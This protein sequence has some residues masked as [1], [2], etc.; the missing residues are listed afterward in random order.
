MDITEGRYLKIK[1]TNGEE[2]SFVFEPLSETSDASM[3]STRVQQM[4][5]S[6]RLMLKTADKLMII[7]LANV[8]SIE[9]SPCPAGALPQAIQVLHE[10]ES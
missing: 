6:G 2:K 1:F 7:P 4:L 9:V 10:F 3:I 5:D 8:I